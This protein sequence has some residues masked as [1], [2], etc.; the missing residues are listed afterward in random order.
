[1]PVF[2]CHLGLVV[3]MPDRIAQQSLGHESQRISPHPL[4]SLRLLEWIS[5]NHLEILQTRGFNIPGDHFR[6]E[7]YRPWAS[8]E[9][10]GPLTSGDK[11]PE[12]DA[13]LEARAFVGEPYEKGRA[14]DEAIRATTA[15]VRGGP[16]IRESA[17]AAPAPESRVEREGPVTRSRGKAPMEVYSSRSTSPVGPVRRPPIVPRV[18]ARGLSRRAP[19]PTSSGAGPSSLQ[20]YYPMP[21]WNVLTFDRRG[22][23]DLVRPRGVCGYP[24]LETVSKIPCH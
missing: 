24:I 10:I 9:L 13:A 15:E 3:Y 16:V 17:P 14:F 7:D 19:P 8:V 2:V 5:S 4:G 1:M 22:E 20:E 21:G 12:A 18:P 23:L 11:D 6:P